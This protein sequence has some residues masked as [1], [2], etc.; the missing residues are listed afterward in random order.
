MSLIDQVLLELLTPKNM[1][2]QMDTMACLI[3]PFGSE[4]VNESLKLLKSTEKYFQ[5]SSP[6]FWA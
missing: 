1:F 5:P 4:R 2:F 6:S 3:K